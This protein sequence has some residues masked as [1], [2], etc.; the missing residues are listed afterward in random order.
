[1]ASNYD[2]RA[3]FAVEKPDEI[4]MRLDM[5]MSLENWKSIRRLG[6]PLR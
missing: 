1:M 6:R 3:H 2:I 4:T 5:S